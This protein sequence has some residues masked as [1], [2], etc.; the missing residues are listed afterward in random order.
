MK[1]Q[2]A[3]L[4]IADCVTV[5]SATASFDAAAQI[6]GSTLSA[7]LALPLALVLVLVLVLVLDVATGSAIAVSLVFSAAGAVLVVKAVE[8]SAQGTV[9]AL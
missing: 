1:H 8:V 3:I 2:F 6:N 5:T 7:V 9:S 4:S